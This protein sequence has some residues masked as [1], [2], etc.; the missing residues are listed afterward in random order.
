MV[1]EGEKETWMSKLDSRIVDVNKYKPKSEN[2][3]LVNVNTFSLDYPIFSCLNEK[4]NTL[5]LE[6]KYLSEYRKGGKF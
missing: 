1:D 3:E 4:E 5:L 2:I 6:S